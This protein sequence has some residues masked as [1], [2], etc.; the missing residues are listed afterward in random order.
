[1]KTGDKL[2]LIKAM[3]QRNAE[4]IRRHIERAA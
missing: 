4:R 2:A 3:E 1:M